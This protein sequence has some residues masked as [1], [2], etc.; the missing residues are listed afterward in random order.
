MCTVTFIPVKGGALIASNRDEKNMRKPA[1]PPDVYMHGITQLTYPK[2]AQ[3]GGTWIAMKQNGDAAVLLNG[4]FTKHIPQ[5]PYAKSR[6]V[7][8]IDIFKDNLPAQAFLRLQLNNIEPFTLLLFVKGVLTECRWD[9]EMKHIKQLSALSAHIWSSATLYSDEVV[10]K[11]ENWFKHWLNKGAAIT[12]DSLVNF[13]HFAGD[14]DKQNDLLMKRGDI[15]QTVSVTVLEL[16]PGHEKMIY[17]DIVQN[18]STTHT[19]NN[20]T[21]ATA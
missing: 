13:H 1:L 21:H 7:I 16:L 6:G 10:A 19:I 14:G 11:R 20:Y 8:L 5:P 15:Y 3:A 18:T 9:G 17:H 4:A 12:T 2:D